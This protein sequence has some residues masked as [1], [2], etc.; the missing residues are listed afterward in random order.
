MGSVNRDHD[1]IAALRDFLNAQ[2]PG[3][4]TNTREVASLLSNCWSA[5]SGSGETTMRADKLWRLE[6]PTWNPPCLS[7]L[8][9]RHGQ[10]AMGSSRATVYKWQVDIQSLTAEVIEQKRRQIYP[11]AKRLNVKPIAEELA[12]AIVGGTPDE[13]LKSTNDGKVRLDVGKIIPATNKQTTLGR[14]RRLRRELSALL[15]P[16]GWTE[17]RANVYARQS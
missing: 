4:I 15:K 17:I 6:E 10:T 8:I 13:R 3:P 16:H 2:P 14:R 1:P 9:E 12:K 5:F 11:M 7:F